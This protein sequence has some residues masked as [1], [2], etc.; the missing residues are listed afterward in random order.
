MKRS[1]VFLCIA[2]SIFLL[3]TNSQAQY[4]VQECNVFVNQAG[5]YDFC[6]FLVT[7]VCPIGDPTNGYS[8]LYMKEDMGINE[9]FPE[10][11]NRTSGEM[12]R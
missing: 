12:I 2:I 6:K 9:E 4:T 11:L 3:S 7:G 5:L 8:H 10:I 1:I